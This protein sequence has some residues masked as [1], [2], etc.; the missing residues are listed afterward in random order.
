M[1]CKGMSLVAALC[2]AVAVLGVPAAAAP[3]AGV[4]DAVGDVR[5]LVRAILSTGDAQGRPFAVVDKQQAS[6]HV[7]DGS[8]RWRG[9][10]AV[11]L[12]QARGDRSAPGVG[13]RTQQGHVPVP[14]R[15][16]PA[17]RF[18]TE[19][20]RNLHGESVVWVDYDLAFAIHRLRPG[21]SRPARAT[22]LAT[23]T[24]DDN[25]VSWGCVVAPEKFY[26]DVVHQLLGRGP[27]VVYV[28]PEHGS[29]LSLLAQRDA[30]Q[31]NRPRLTALGAVD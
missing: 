29:P 5:V 7:F 4:D 19:P 20:G 17:G 6:L 24:P 25:R 11:L 8:G 22:R 16:T 3:A 12:G 18:E 30:A 15:T 26:L 2:L 23:A 28:L 31:A 13:H 21:A 14:E 27:A 1:Q 10:S 9:S